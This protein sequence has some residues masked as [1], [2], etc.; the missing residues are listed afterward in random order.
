MGES[1]V[2]TDI[3]AAGPPPDFDVS[4]RV[5]ALAVEGVLHELG[6]CLNRIALE[7]ALMQ[8]RL[9]PEQRSAVETIRGEVR[10][11]A[12]T[13]RPLQQAQKSRQPPSVVNLADLVPGAPKPGEHVSIEAN[14]DDVRLLV[15]LLNRLAGTESLDLALSDPGVSIA[16]SRQ[17][18]SP[19]AGP[20][21]YADP[22]T[23]AALAVLVK[24]TGGRAEWSVR[25]N[26]WTYSVR[27]SR[28]AHADRAG[29][30]DARR[31]HA[32]AQ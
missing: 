25:G 30:Q 24:R 21:E 6:N 23:A 27:W 9:S 4:A 12:N 1:S 11:A 32:G 26:W 31:H 18:Q 16:V 14:L 10:A 20:D 15:V 2:N 13:L 28:L 7:A 8:A 19:D 3:A 5:Y 29:A 22:L 17:A